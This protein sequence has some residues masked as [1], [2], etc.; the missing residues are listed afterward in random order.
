MSFNTYKNNMEIILEL[1]NPLII[2][3]FEEKFAS[4][5]SLELDAT[6][7]NSL[8][9]PSSEVLQLNLKPVFKPDKKNKKLEKDEETEI[10]K[11]RLKLKKKLREKIDFDEEYDSI[12]EEDKMNNNSLDISSLSVQRPIKPKKLEVSSVSINVGKITNTNIVKK[13]KNYQTFN[14]KDLDSTSPKKPEMVTISTSLTVQELSS[15]FSINQV[16]LI[17]NLFLKGIIVNLN[18]H[19]DTQTCIS[20]GQD[21]GIEV[22]IVAKLE[23]LQEQKISFESIEFDELQPRSP[24]ITIVGHVD[25][26]KT[27]LLD[28]IRKTQIAQKESGGI[29]QKLG[30]YEIEIVYKEENRKLVFVDTPGHEAFSGMRSRGMQVTDIA[31]LVVAADDGVR[32][33]T[34]EAINCIKKAK[35]PLLVAINKIDK[36]DA[37]VENIKQE[38][39]KYDLISESWGGDTLMVPISAKQ[40]TNI[41]TLLEMILLTAEV[42]NFRANFDRVAEG[43]I[44]ESYIDRSKGPVASILVQNGTLKVGDVFVSRDVM[45]KVRGIINS[46]GEKI[47]AAPP[48]SPV[49]VWGLSKPPK[50]GDLFSVYLNEKDAKIAVQEAELNMDKKSSNFASQ[51]NYSISEFDSKGSISLIVKADIQGSIE[52]IT[53]TLNNLSTSKVPVKILYASL[54]EITETDIEFANTSK[55]TILAFNTTLAPGASKSAKMLNVFVKESNVIYDLFDYV[56]DLIDS[57]LGP[58]YDEQFIGSA[59]VKSIFPLG[60]SYVAGVRVLEGKLTRSSHIKITRSDQIIYQGILHSL[61]RLKDEVSEVKEPLE[62][63]I[64]L[65]DFD[66]WKENDTIKAF[67]LVEKRKEK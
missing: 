67:N 42:E 23:D 60:K 15:L 24:I 44:L 54:G 47:S 3:S 41:D 64:F 27:T 4:N 11:T 45:G 61:K 5:N 12:S 59:S 31:V 51:D 58:E 43:T 52:A 25:H 19:I 53:N 50:T 32:P 29:T 55:A 10:N 21:F 62:C 49:L 46:F 13:K 28:K 38:L 8:H 20:I 1:F 30:A 16:D 57:I 63:G 7:S 65:K 18:S 48:S 35:V 17:K 40:G 2:K 9:S 39:S 22:K 37:N 66:G 56:Q 36:S 33:Q 6:E 26:G 14:K 34:I